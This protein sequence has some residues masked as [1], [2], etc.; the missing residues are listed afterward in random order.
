MNK[1]HLVEV[2]CNSSGV[3][4]RHLMEVTEHSDY[5]SA[6]YFAQKKIEVVGDEYFIE[7]RESESGEKVTSFNEA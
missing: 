6:F 3:L 2:R 4:T 7:I 5:M 1:K